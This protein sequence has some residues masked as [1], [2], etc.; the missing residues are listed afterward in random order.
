MYIHI[1][2][3]CVCICICIETC[4]ETCIRICKYTHIFISTRHIS[5]VSSPLETLRQVAALGAGVGV[6]VLV[7]LFEA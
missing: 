3:M 5:R 4:I 7:S 6:M 2:Y 1:L